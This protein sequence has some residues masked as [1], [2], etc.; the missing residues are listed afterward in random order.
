MLP[1]AGKL[2]RNGR[3]ALLVASVV[4]GSAQERVGD[5]TTK[6]IAEHWPVYN[7]LSL[8][9]VWSAVF[10][11]SWSAAILLRV[12]LLPP[13]IAGALLRQ[14]GACN[15]RDLIERSLTERRKHD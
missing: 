11:G 5:S 13:G 6:W 14:E 2:T 8:F 15:D 12:A 10:R 3:R 1:G 7:H 4:G 9:L